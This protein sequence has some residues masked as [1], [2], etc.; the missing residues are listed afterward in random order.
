MAARQ[1]QDMGPNERALEKAKQRRAA[2]MVGFTR[3]GRQSVVQA[4]AARE[5]LARKSKER[6]PEAKTDAFGRP[7]GESTLSRAARRLQ[8]PK[9]KVRGYGSGQVGG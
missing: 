3:P 4:A 1:Y 8:G 7:R 5:H 9:N 2:G 6:T